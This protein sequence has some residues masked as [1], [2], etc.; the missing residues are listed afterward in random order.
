ML[1]LRMSSTNVLWE[2]PMVPKD[3]NYKIRAKSNC[4]FYTSQ[5]TSQLEEIAVQS[6]THDVFSDRIQPELFGSI[7]PIDGIL[8]PNDDVIVSFNE[9]INE[10]AFNTS[11]AQTYIEVMAR[12]NRTAHTH[13]SYLYFGSDDSLKI[14]SGVYLNNSFTIEMWLK[15]ESNGV[16]F[17]Q[18]NGTDSEVIKMS[19]VDFDTDPKL[20]FDYIHP[21]DVTKN[22][23][24]NHSIVLPSTG[25]TH[26]ALAYD[27]ENHE[28]IFLDGTG[29]VATPSYS[30]NMN[31]VGDGPIIAGALYKGAMHDLRVW[32]KVAGDIQAN[33]SINLSGKEA[34]LV[35]YWP[36]DEL[37]SNPKDKARYRDA[38]TSAQWAVES[39]N[40]ALKLDYN[41][42]LIEDFSALQDSSTLAIVNGSDF[43]IELWFNTAVSNNQT[44]LS[45][46]SWDQGDKFETWSFDINAGAIEIYQGDTIYAPILNT[47]TTY[48]DGEWHHMA[49]VKNASSNTRLY[50]D[51]VE[52][53]QVDSEFV[54]GITSSSTY[55]GH[56][57]VLDTEAAS[58]E[59]T[60]HYNG[61]IDEIRIWNIEKSHDRVLSEMNSNISEKNG[62]SQST[63]FNQIELNS[64]II[65]LSELD[66]PL[67]RASE[68]KTSVSFHDVSNGDQISINLTE[69]L[70]RI[71]NTSIDFTL[72]E[73]RDLSGNLIE[74]PVTWTTY[75][76]KNQLIWGNEFIEM[77]KLLSESLS[78]TTHIINQGG[79]VENFQISNLPIWL[80]AYPSEGFL[81]PNS[82]TQIEFI[83]NED[84]FIGHYKE[85]ILLVGNNEY[86][87][88]M[89]FNLN[90]E[91][92]QPEYYVD[93]Q[94]YEYVMNFVGKVTVE[95]IRSRDEMD[96][97][98]AYVG[99]ELR[100][101]TTPTYIEEYDSYIIFLSVY[102]D[103]LN[104]EEVSFRLWDASAGKFQTRVKINGQDL[105][106]FQPSFVIGSFTELAHFEA[107][108]I[109]RQDI[110][111][112]EGWNWVSF[113]LNSLDE[114]DGLDDVLQVPTVMNEV[115]GSSITIFK[116]QYAFTQYAE[117]D[118]YDDTW[119]G[120]LTEIPITDMFMIKSQKSDT[121]IY[122]GKIVN[123]SEVPIDVSAGWNWI[124]YLGQRIMG[125]NDALSSLNPSSGDVIKNKSAFSMYA[126]ESLGWLGTLNS[127][128]SGHGYML[129]T[130]S[131]GSLIYPESSIFRIRDYQISKNQISDELIEVSNALYQNSMSMVAKID[132]EKFTQPD[133]SNVLA[134][135][136]DQ[137]CLGNINATQINE[138]E[139]LYFITI[140]GE[141]GYNVSFKYFDQVNGESFKAENTLKFEANK[142]IGSIQDPYPII[143]TDS[144][145]DLLIEYTLDV[146]PNPFKKEFEVEFTL[147]NEEFISIDIFDVSGRKVKSLYNGLLKS[148]LHNLDIDAS[149]IAKGSYF[150]EL[151]LNDSSFRKIIIKS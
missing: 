14:P 24:V 36:M 18:S 67:I 118:G 112:N 86:A 108:N 23:M 123:P 22:Q 94:D 60:N 101:A 120:S 135:Y 140:Y 79:T 25:F 74:S 51:G 57:R 4:G 5:T 111:L 117:I 151:K 37:R 102:G 65:T 80:N 66:V 15:P 2:V 30:F 121:I 148:G 62:L 50:L 19:V 99:E 115:D 105:H 100:G 41:P 139:S 144:P 119:I 56:R 109:L 45:L 150:I 110:V 137:L 12:K 122:E 116:N 49:M 90:V 27:A 42:A 48:N 89:E 113:N 40:K 125:T 98:F 20:Q 75:I 124:S 88:R 127:M 84:L 16:L 136:S 10:I 71:E 142:L 149:D 29:S 76:D 35:G 32:S 72:Q 43:T 82:Y 47:N 131:T 143:L 114:E 46:G 85:D 146:Y 147:D 52:V 83:V 87:E 21:A 103:Q 93:P 77:E 54:G 91:M 9:P 59:Y 61:L 134:A 13:D 126:S 133:L 8:N 44:L 129:K 17:E 95:G 132:L 130:E 3:G 78:F 145:E 7:Q 26:L 53:D 96:I 69:P 55:L 38:Q 64:E 73:V 128:E 106:D 107:T 141:E 28:V 104:G 34:N 6:L 58:V 11:S 70:S 97:L 1:S 92:E 31:Y 68:L 33:R 63:D 138:E 39:E 81:N